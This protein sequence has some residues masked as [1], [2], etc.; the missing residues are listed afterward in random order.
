M[1]IC[2][3]C[4]QWSSYGNE[5]V[6]VGLLFVRAYSLGWSVWPETENN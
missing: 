4:M 6:A 5:N 3:A 1:D 2:F